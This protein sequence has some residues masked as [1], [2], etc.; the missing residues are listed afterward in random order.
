MS[1][2]NVQQ[3]NDGTREENCTYICSKTA[4]MQLA[5]KANKPRTAKKMAM[6]PPTMPIPFATNRT[7]Q[8]NAA[9]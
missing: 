1:T 5:E 8:G 3:P 6:N 9:D 4:M 2:H 7:H